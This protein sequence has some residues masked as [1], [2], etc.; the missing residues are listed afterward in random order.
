MDNEPARKARTVV[1]ELDHIGN[2]D[3]IAGC[4]A[5]A[6]RDV[7]RTDR[8][9]SFEMHRIVRIAAVGVLER[10]V[11]HHGQ[12]AGD[13][14]DRD[15]ESRDLFRTA[16]RIV[17]AAELIPTDDQISFLEQM[18]VTA[19]RRLKAGMDIVRGK[20]QLVLDR[21]VVAGPSAP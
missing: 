9:P 2:I 13:G 4:V 8:V 12:L 17:V 20:N 6:V 16:V 7:T 3:G 14:I 19:I 11:L 5:V 15:R 18:D 10:N 21:L 1:L